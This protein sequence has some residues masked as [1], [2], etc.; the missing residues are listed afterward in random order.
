MGCIGTPISGLVT[1]GLGV[2]PINGGFPGL[3]TAW[4]FQLLCFDLRVD[5][6]QVGGSRPLA[7]GEIQNFYTPVDPRCYIPQKHVQLCVTLIR[8]GEKIFFTRDYIVT[9]RQA[10][11]VVKITRIIN[12]THERLSV[13]AQNFRRAID[14]SV[15][16]TNLKRVAREVSVVGRK[17]KRVTI[18]NLRKRDKDK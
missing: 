11:M 1:Y 15:I 3:I 7:P 4:H 9:V 10:S 13:L 14:N 12:K 8:D 2:D 16:T 18:E 5:L 6:F 17:I